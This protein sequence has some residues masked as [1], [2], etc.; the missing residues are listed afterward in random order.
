VRATFDGMPYEGSVVSMGSQHVIGVQKAVRAQLGK[1]PG[2][3]VTVT[4]V[5]DAGE[6]TVSVPDDL[7]AA[8]EEAGLS[9]RFAGLSFT[10]R[11]EY[12][13]WVDEA[14]KPETRARR[15]G[16]TAERLRG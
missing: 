1:Q 12:V 9:E 16:R 7:V 3:V 14:K 2:D 8:L 13:T 5:V 15:I 10:H 4:L 11:R 6:R